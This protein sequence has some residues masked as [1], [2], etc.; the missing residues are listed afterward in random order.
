MTLHFVLS[1]LIW[2]AHILNNVTRV[3]KNVRKEILLWDILGGEQS[4]YI[5]YKNTSVSSKVKQNSML[6]A[7]Q[8]FSVFVMS[9]NIVFAPFCTPQ[10]YTL[11][12]EMNIFPRI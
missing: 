6:H 3:D 8:V 5:Y 10:T 7:E 11:I 1:G 2:V 12:G 9:E 4:F